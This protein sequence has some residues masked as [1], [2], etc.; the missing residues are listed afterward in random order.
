M[1]FETRE[2][3]RG[4]GGGG[5]KVKI[6]LGRTGPRGRVYAAAPKGTTVIAKSKYIRAG[7]GARAG[8]YGHLRYIQER[9]RGEGEP[10]RKF[11]DREK[12][13]IERKDVYDAMMAGRGG[14]AA[15]HTLI[16]SP[17]D[18]TVDLA[19]YT[20]ASMKSLEERLG[21]EL[22]WYATTHENTDHNHA[23]VV[24]AGKKPGREQEYERQERVSRA[25]DR[26]AKG[27]W[28]G[29]QKDLKEVLGHLYDEKATTD[30]RE[31]RLEDGKFSGGE[32]REPTDPR[33]KDLIGDTTRS[34][35]ELKTEKML[36]RFERRQ[37]A[38]EAGKQRS[39]LYLD[40]N[41]LKE[42]RDAGND[43]MARERSLDRE[44]D[45]SLE[46][47]MGRDML[48]LDRD[49]EREHGHERLDDRGTTRGERGDRSEDEEKKRGRDDFDRG[50]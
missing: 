28:S 45:R 13:G 38:A 41:D 21:H 49:R 40:K 1:W 26:N 20:R 33:V 34:V 2:P 50:R 9:E 25:I 18:N 35:A 10:E 31:D 17:G 7:N 47:E 27:A 23:H 32:D 14:K 44:I 30:P 15:M 4:G 37:A 46:K 36:D 29:E 19:D 43:Y 12:E 16:L 6:A 48:S 5:G 11:F 24:I 42:L 8:I 22:D 39:D 3:K